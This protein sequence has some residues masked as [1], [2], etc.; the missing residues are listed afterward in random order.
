MKFTA[1]LALLFAFTTAFAQIPQAFNYQAVARDANGNALA[2]RTVSV[3]YT[4][5]DGVPT[6]NILYIETHTGVQTN[7]FGLF[8]AKVGGGTVVIGNFANIP[9]STGHKSLQVEYDPNGGSSYTNMGATELLSVPYALYA[10]TSANGPQGLKGDTGA[11]GPQGPIGL[12]GPTGPAGNAT[13]VNGVVNYI[14]KITPDTN[15]LSNSQL[16]DDGTYVG[17]GTAAPHA[18]LSINGDLLAKTVSIAEADFAG[19]TNECD[20]C[21]NNLVFGDSTT[22]LTGISMRCSDYM[23][24]SININGVKLPDLLQSNATW[25]GAQGAT[26]AGSATNTQD[27]SIDNA[28]HSCNCPDGSIATG[29]EIY[30]SDRLDGRMKLRCATLK[31]GLTTSNTGIGLKTAF[32]VPYENA[33]NTRHMSMCPFGM[34]VKGISIYANQKFDLNLCVYCTGIKEN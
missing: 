19:N 33:D 16:F 25:Y 27:V 21:Y 31:T 34:Y 9:W 10:V 2:N 1:L 18:K 6:G 24:G 26:A 13:I 4:I 22:A 7:Q 29:I 30:A 3:K 32:S 11:I 12:T 15:T 8:T 5:L 20:N 14:P 23:E 28:I 17:I